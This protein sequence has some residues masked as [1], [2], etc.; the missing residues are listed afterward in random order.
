MSKDQLA[1]ADIVV[2]GA[3]VMGASI[4]FQLT[5]N[6]DRKVIIVDERP[7]VGGASGRTFGQIRQHYSNE[8]MIHMAIRGFEVLN[9]WPAEVGFGDPGYVRLGYM[10]IVVS[11]QVEAC[12][13]NIELGRGLGVDT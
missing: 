3:G 7:P 9:N 5:K 4:A 10:L 12:R 6:S 2:I 13:R 11:E 8:L 1:R